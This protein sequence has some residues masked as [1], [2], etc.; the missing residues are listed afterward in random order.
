MGDSSKLQERLAK[1]NSMNRGGAKKKSFDASDALSRS[2]SNTHRGRYYSIA[3]T[4]DDLKKI[5]KRREAQ[6]TEKQVLGQQNQ[7]KYIK[8]RRNVLAGVDDDSK[9]TEEADTVVVEETSPEAET[10]LSPVSDAEMKEKE[11]K[12]KSKSKSPDTHMTDKAPVV[13]RNRAAAKSHEPAKLT[14]AQT[15]PELPSKKAT[16][17]QSAMGPMGP[18]VVTQS[19]KNVTEVQSTARKQSTGGMAKLRGFL[20]KSKDNV[21]QPS[22]LKFQ[23]PN[24]KGETF[25][26]F[27][28]LKPTKL[29][30][31]G[32]YAAVCEVVD[33]RTKK[34]Y[35]VKKN[36]D[37]F[38]NVADARRILRE[39]KLM[40]HF[41]HPHVMGLVGVIP[42]EAHDRD[43]YKD[44]YLIMPRMDTTLSK[45][46][47]SKQKLSARH[48]QYFIYQIAR[49]LEYM[50]SGGIIHRDL[51]PEN[52]LVNAADC[53]VKITDFGLSRGVHL[54]ADTP[55]KLTE[56]VVT[57]WYRAPEVMCCSR[58]YD[59]QIDTW[60][61]GCISAELYHRR[62]IFKGRNHIEQ[63]QLIFH[64]MGTPNDLSW[65]T[66][67]DAQ[68]WIGGMPKKPPQ[69][70]SKI[71]PGATEQ[72]K[73]F[74]ANLLLTNPHNR[75]TITQALKHPWMKEFARDKDYKKCPEFNISFEYEA[76]IKTSF[77]VR[78]MMY[79]ELT[80]FHERCQQQQDAAQQ[81]VDKQQ[82][83]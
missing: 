11:V 38:S 76:R 60:A 29:L 51:K 80:Q 77:G 26:L 73:A 9:D 69:D 57:R 4:R 15:A 23:L 21:Q 8:S 31:E 12:P 71:M 58:L 2:Q 70:L 24:S 40:I 5:T 81:A 36:R 14:Q 27:P 39:I 49:G 64:Y 43:T 18:S 54:D 50:H 55:Q 63:L 1:L 13:D 65:I 72:A 28:W 35:A 67:Q 52:I 42:P 41:D 62:P 30:G 83:H 59:Y 17:S 3:N 44:C 37:V 53:K 68:K 34:K 19:A 45:V 33:N 16:S 66:T 7:R 10:P 79:T 78:H 47:R 32:A 22:R 25:E 61:L 48:I 74:V 46:I 56:Y 75:P 82:Q 20:R 6:R